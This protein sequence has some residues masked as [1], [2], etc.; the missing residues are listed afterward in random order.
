[1]LYMVIE[2]FKNG[3]AAPVGK[4]FRSQGRM[5]PD[6]VRYHASWMDASGARC[7]QIMETSV[8]DSLREWMGHWSD[9]VD[10]EVIPVKTS[11]E[12][13]GGKS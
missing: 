7:F 8:P 2:N 1:M 4:R 9:L 11:A 12:F 5:L 3:D 6:G 10:F 13:W